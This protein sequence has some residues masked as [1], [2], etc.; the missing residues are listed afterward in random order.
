MDDILEFIEFM[1]FAEEAE[2]APTLRR[3]IRDNINPMEVYTPL[4]FYRRYRCVNI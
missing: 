4:E 1:Q 2:G 3:Y